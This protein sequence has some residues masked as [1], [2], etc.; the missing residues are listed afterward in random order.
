MHN[1]AE[2][3]KLKGKLQVLRNRGYYVSIEKERGK[4][5]RIVISPEYIYGEDGVELIF[6]NPE[7]SIENMIDLLI[8]VFDDEYSGPKPTML[9]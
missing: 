8:L 3:Y 9:E 6:T 5:H 1:K 2:F 7:W 4:L